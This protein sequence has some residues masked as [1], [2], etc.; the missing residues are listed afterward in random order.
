M[1]QAAMR[2]GPLKDAVRRR[3]DEH[4]SITACQRPARTTSGAPCCQRQARYGADNA[5]LPPLL[6]YI[7]RVE[8]NGGAAA[9][10]APVAVV[11]KGVLLPS[12]NHIPASYTAP[13]ESNKKMRRALCAGGSCLSPLATRY[14]HGGRRA[15]AYANAGVRLLPPYHAATRRATR[16]RT[17]QRDG[18]I[19]LSRDEKSCHFVSYIISPGDLYH[20]N[21]S[22]LHYILIVIVLL[23]YFRC[24]VS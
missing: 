10:N 1:L 2:S 14:R 17:Q 5:P 13:R 23:E 20:I 9:Y 3:Q 16:E 6:P 11:V 21:I 12:L 4:G 22:D 15:H 18:I 7:R 19:M 24:I 8:R